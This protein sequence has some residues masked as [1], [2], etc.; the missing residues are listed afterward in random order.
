MRQ[1][2]HQLPWRRRLHGSPYYDYPTSTPDKRHKETGQDDTET[3]DSAGG[4][5]RHAPTAHPGHQGGLEGSQD[6]R[7]STVPQAGGLDQRL[8]P[9]AGHLSGE[10]WA[11]SHGSQHHT[12]SHHSC[13]SW[14]WHGAA[15][16]TCQCESKL[17]DGDHHYLLAGPQ[18]GKFDWWGNIVEEPFLATHWCLSCAAM[19]VLVAQLLFVH[20]FFAIG[21]IS[22]EFT[23]YLLTSAFCRR[24][25]LQLAAMNN[26]YM[27]RLTTMMIWINTIIPACSFLSVSVYYC[28]TRI[29]SHELVKTSGNAWS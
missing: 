9:Q 29:S 15:G 11:S 10:K 16:H 3:K 7:D 5:P 12:G 18:C 4:A 28:A 26:R 8:P 13:G 14:D 21:E 19:L 25:Q 22:N 1:P 2:S 27:A 17:R 24:V 20:D 6:G 23:K